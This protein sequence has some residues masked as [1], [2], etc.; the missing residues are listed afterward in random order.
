[1]VSY[2]VRL[3]NFLWRQ[4]LKHLVRP[5]KIVKVH[6]HKMHLDSK[7]SLLLSLRKNYEPKHVR[8]L[9][10]NVKPGD[11][12]VDIGA[13][14]G[15][16]TLILADIVGPT[17]KVYSFEPNPETFKILKKNV[18]TN[19]YKN[20]VLEQKAVSNKKGRIKLYL[21]KINTGDS[22]IHEVSDDESFKY[23][24]FNVESVSLDSYFKN[25]KR[26]NFFK[27]DIQGAEPLALEGMKK[28]LKTKNL[29]FTMEFSPENLHSFGFNPEKILNTLSKEGYTLV[30][31]D[32]QRLLSPHEFKK[33]VRHYE[34]INY[35]TTIYA[36]KK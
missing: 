32:K 11:Y 14:I 21:S 12:V 29:K 26:I 34:K 4:A 31:L 27:M 30:D 28:L 3:K 18:E 8:L 22:R 6:R 7:D 2:S 1:M 10:K 9:R 15:Y 5:N 20:V 13:H 23:K 36:F 24:E 17:G 35:F 33:F 19:G 25:V 16:Y